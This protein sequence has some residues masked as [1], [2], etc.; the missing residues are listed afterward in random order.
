MNK[1]M[2]LSCALAVLIPATWVAAES[3]DEV[4]PIDLAETCIAGAARTADHR[5][6][7]NAKDAARTVSKVRS[8]LRAGKRKQAARAAHQGI[9]GI[10]RHSA[11]SIEAISTRCRRC[12]AILVKM[13]HPALARSVAA[14]CDKQTD[15]IQRSRRAAIARISAALGSS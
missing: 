13:G 15:R 14:A 10:N 9:A 8:L 6:A 3:P 2:W 7:A 12:V 1:R 11:A 4:D 5:V